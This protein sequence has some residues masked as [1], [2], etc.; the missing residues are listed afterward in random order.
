MPVSKHVFHTL[1][2]HFIIFSLKRPFFYTPSDSSVVMA[3]SPSSKMSKMSGSSSRS[4][5]R[6]CPCKVHRRDDTTVLEF[7]GYGTHRIY[8]IYKY[9]IYICYIYTYMLYIYKYY[10]YATCIHIYIYTY[11]ISYG[12][13]I[14]LH[15]IWNIT[16][17]M[18]TDLCNMI[19]NDCDVPCHNLNMIM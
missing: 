19:I 15:M 14:C 9:Y 2:P 4:M 1:Y 8:V 17:N 10:L 13:M 18:R 12:T 16:C 7:L 5:S 11:V 3:P 6:T